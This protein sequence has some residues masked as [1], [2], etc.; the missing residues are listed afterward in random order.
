MYR[1]FDI[2]KTKNVL[3]FECIYQLTTSNL[4]AMLNLSSVFLCL[5][6][7]YMCTYICTVVSENFVHNIQTYVCMHVC[8]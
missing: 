7:A 8:I 5:Y 3:I 6:N 4:N 2:A 1:V